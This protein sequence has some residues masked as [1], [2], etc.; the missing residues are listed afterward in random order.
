MGQTRV[1]ECLGA[2]DFPEV[3][4]PDPIVAFWGQ[5]GGPGMVGARFP[6][7]PRLAASNSKLRYQLSTQTFPRRP[8]L[9]VRQPLTPK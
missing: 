4:V 5:N 6:L 8:K 2:W 7:Q 3:E 1:R 9:S